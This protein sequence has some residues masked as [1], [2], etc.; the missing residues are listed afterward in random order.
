MLSRLGHQRAGD[1]SARHLHN[2]HPNWFNPVSH[3]ADARHAGR[4]EEA[5]PP[6]GN[7]PDRSL[8]SLS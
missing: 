2:C 4:K 6:W 3:L 8:H 5:A 1:L 7:P